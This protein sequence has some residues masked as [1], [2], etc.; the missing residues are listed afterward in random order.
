MGV[1]L[2][3]VS[4]SFDSDIKIKNLSY[5][6]PE[7]G[8]VAITGDSGVGKTTLARMI[9]GLDEDF[10]GEII[11]GGIGKCAVA[12]QEYRLFP[13][14][15]ALDNVIFSRYDKKR[16]DLIEHA[17]E[18]LIKL[19][20][21]QD[22]LHLRPSQLS[23]GMKQR[24]SL[25]RALFSSAPIIILDEATKELDISL[26]E[27]VISIISEEAEKRLVILVTHD[28]EE[29]KKLDADVLHLTKLS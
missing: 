8:V 4:K 29:I 12:F 26:K 18:L 28:P 15:T 17:S 27:R 7:K 1:K 3:N 19:G 6:F 23:G 16:R 20:L 21:N 13:Q 2:I 22:A 10:H 25:A 14:L 5:E 24:V 9:C 11:G